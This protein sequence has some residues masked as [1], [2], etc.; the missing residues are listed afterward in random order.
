MREIIAS[1]SMPFFSVPFLIMRLTSTPTTKMA[2]NTI[3]M[4]SPLS[5]L[6]PPVKYR[7]LFVIYCFGISAPINLP[8]HFLSF[9]ESLIL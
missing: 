9:P 6:L 4:M 1:A 2:A 3:H 5:I 7:L 8:A